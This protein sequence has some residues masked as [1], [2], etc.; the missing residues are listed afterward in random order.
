MSSGKW[1]SKPQWDN[2]SYPLGWLESKTDINT[3][4]WGYGGIP[5]TLIHCWWD[6][7]RC[8][9]FVK[10]IWQF[11][12]G[13]TQSHH[14][15]SNSTLRNTRKWKL[16]HT[17]DLKLFEIFSIVKIIIV[18]HNSQLVECLQDAKAWIQSAL[19]SYVESQPNYT[20]MSHCE[21]GW[22]PLVLTLMLFCVNVHRCIIHD[23]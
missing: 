14:M 8:N 17:V 16:V 7:K 5:R 10:N 2:V 19:P 12:L 18:L 15:I 13:W 4:C 3:C 20:H 21:K 23:R 22:E 1:K 6:W 11:L 9:H